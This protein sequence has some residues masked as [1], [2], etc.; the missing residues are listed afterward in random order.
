MIIFGGVSSDDV[1]LVVQHHPHRIVPTR[2]YST[3]NVPGRSGDLLDMQAAW[4]NYTQTYDVFLC[5]GKKGD[6]PKLARAVAAW[7]CGK[8]GYQRL[9]ESYDP[10]T[11]RM[12]YFVGP[13]DIED[14]LTRYGKCTMSFGCK[15]QRYLKDG[16]HMVSI[17]QSGGVMLNPT[18][19][20]AKPLL[21]IQ[22]SGAGSVTVGTT[23]VFILSSGVFSPLCID[24]ETGAAYTLSSSG[25]RIDR[26]G[27]ISAYDLPVLGAGETAISWT[28]AV[29]G[30]DILPRWWTL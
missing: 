7:L 10:N 3:A 22:S 30:V 9:E 12:A 5:G 8:P 19:F 16:E 2:K 15:P 13:L 21:Q 24:C 14:R 6:V 29:S 28:G 18:V 11:Y 4:Q 1:R 26:N 20:P 17:T 23:S 27:S 25:G